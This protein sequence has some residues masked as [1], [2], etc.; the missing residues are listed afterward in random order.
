[1]SLL[2]EEPKPSSRADVRRA[3][4]ALSIIA[5]GTVITG[6]LRADGTIKIE[7]EVL[8]NVQ[9]AQQ[10]LLARGSHVR[11]D[12]QAR[13][14]VIGGVVEGAIRA[15]DRVEIQATAVVTGDVTTQRI[16]IAEGGQVNGGLVMTRKPMGSGPEL[17]KG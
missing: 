10:V 1:M 7:G 13:E 8:G 12:V 15:T 2:R 17:V 16:V 11:G 14:A 6:D 4:G 9:A 3:D 5:S